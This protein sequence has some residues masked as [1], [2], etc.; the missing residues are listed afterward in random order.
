[1]W[2]IYLINLEGNTSRFE[3]CKTQFQAENIDFERIEAINGWN[4][5]EQEISAVYDS[6]SNKKFGRYPLTKPEIGCYLSHLK[7]WKKIANS[8]DNGGF[9]FEDDFN[10]ITS[11]NNHP[12]LKSILELISNDAK[13]WDM[14]KLFSY[15]PK[16]N[17]ID[18]QELG[19]GYSIV[20]PYKIPQCALGYALRRDSAQK[21]INHYQT[22]FRPVDED[23]KFFWEHGLDIKL[24]TP[25]PLEIGCQES[26]TG[27]IT[28]SRVKRNSFRNRAH[29]ILH[30]IIYRLR[31]ILPLYW[32]RTKS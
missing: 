23:L 12:H 11:T 13:D 26:A 32:H 8:S 10:I 4:L 31:Y 29:Q 28:E 15:H 20:T 22:F 2:P 18:M 5:A 1:M 24:I 6:E 3:N 30:N 21:L 19:G 7:A 25:C 9:I 27:T 17:F 16:N 14:V